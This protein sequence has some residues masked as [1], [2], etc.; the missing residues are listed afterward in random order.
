MRDIL[1]GSVY[2]S[3]F[4]VSLEPGKLIDRDD[5]YHIIATEAIR[6]EHLNRDQS[7][8][9]HDFFVAYKLWIGPACD[10]THV[11]GVGTLIGHE[12]EGAFEG[13]GATSIYFGE[14]GI[15]AGDGDG[16][17]D[18]VSNRASVGLS[19]WHSTALWVALHDGVASSYTFFE[20]GD[21]LSGGG[22]VALI[23]EV[24][25]DSD[26]DDGEDD[27]FAREET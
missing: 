14:T 7:P 19:P 2:L 15:G 26:K 10:I 20:T 21:R 6:A 13:D 22:R 16:S 17:W 18:G 12:A 1:Q 11:K 9:D 25:E 24:S 3:K 8:L 4:F 27:Y 5:P 23:I